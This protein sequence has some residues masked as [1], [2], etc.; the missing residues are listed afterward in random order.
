MTIS[1][2]DAA[3]IAA[4]QPVYESAIA[5][6]PS[7]KVIPLVEIFAEYT[8]HSRH[9]ASVLL[10]STSFDQVLEA[11]RV[12]PKANF[13]ESVGFLSP[14]ERVRILNLLIEYM[15]GI[16]NGKELCTLSNCLPPAWKKAAWNRLDHETQARLNKLPKQQQQQQQGAK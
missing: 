13:E 12:L 5:K 3:R 9:L 15:R 8:H 16:K 4:S 2:K 1:N 7:D 6:F 11:L 10:V 14:E